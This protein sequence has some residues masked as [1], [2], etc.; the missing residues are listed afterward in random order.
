MLVKLH[1]TQIVII[2]IYLFIITPLSNMFLVAF[3]NL[4]P[5]DIQR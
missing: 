4:T 5:A 1:I 2:F 3:W